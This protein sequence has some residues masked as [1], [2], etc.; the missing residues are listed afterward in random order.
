MLDAKP[1]QKDV[2]ISRNFREIQRGGSVVSS[3]NTSEIKK[4]TF[5]PEQ[6]KALRELEQLGIFKP[7][8]KNDV[9]PDIN[10]KTEGYSDAT[11]KL[12]AALYKAVT[13][14]DFPPSRYNSPT[15]DVNFRLEID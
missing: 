1:A 11:V 4:T 14:K 7:S 12:W 5:N 3:E 8:N 9:D 2:M 15:G 13:G 6:A 10:Y